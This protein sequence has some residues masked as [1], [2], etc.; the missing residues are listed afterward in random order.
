MAEIKVVDENQ[1][2]KEEK[3]IKEWIYPLSKHGYPYTCSKECK[4]PDTKAGC[5]GCPLA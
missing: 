4:R 2:S 5:L 3:T 1:K